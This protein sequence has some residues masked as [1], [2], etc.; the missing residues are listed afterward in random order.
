MKSSNPICEVLKSHQYLDDLKKPF[1][2]H[3]LV[4]AVTGNQNH[5]FEYEENNK[6]DEDEDAFG[7]RMRRE[8]IYD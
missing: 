5:S 4:L 6:R 2:E 7:R 3:E 1:R 8:G